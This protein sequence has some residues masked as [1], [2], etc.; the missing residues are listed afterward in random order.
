[1]VKAGFDKTL[2]KEVLKIQK[3]Y[4]EVCCNPQS[5]GWCSL[6]NTAFA[7][8]EHEH[9]CEAGIEFLSAMGTYKYVWNRIAVI[10]PNILKNG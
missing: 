5:C 8:L 3:R 1:M 9:N 7:Q 4:P 10:Y 2:I 6:M